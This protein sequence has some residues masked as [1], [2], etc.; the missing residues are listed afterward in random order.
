MFQESVDLLGLE[1]VD[2]PVII[3]LI[4]ALFIHYFFDY[5]R[6][7]LR[8]PC[9][10][11]LRGTFGSGIFEYGEGIFFLFAEGQVSVFGDKCC[12]GGLVV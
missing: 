12:L 2:L 3:V 5:H 11:I 1:D 4:L 8:T 6:L 9:G 7:S 10:C